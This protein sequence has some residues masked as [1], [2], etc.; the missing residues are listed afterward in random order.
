MNSATTSANKRHR[1]ASIGVLKRMVINGPYQ[2][3]YLPSGIDSLKKIYIIKP[4]DIERAKRTI[5]HLEGL[6]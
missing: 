3:V 5:E 4:E 6:I 1:K 2:T